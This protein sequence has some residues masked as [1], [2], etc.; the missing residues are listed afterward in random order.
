MPR[1]GSATSIGQ[2]G[3]TARSASERSWVARGE[4]RTTVQATGAGGVREVEVVVQRVA[5]L[6]LPRSGT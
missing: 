4:G 1:F 2:K 6:P 5:K 3:E